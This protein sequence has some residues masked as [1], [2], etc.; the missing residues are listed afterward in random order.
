MRKEHI[1]LLCIALVV[2]IVAFVWWLGH[3]PSFEE[4]RASRDQFHAYAMTMPKTAA[5]LFSLIYIIAVAVSIPLATPLSLLAGFLFGSVWGTAIVVVSATIGATFTFVLARFFFREYFETK[6]AS[7]G[8]RATSH[9]FGTFGDVLIARLIPAVPFSLINV[10]AGLTQVSLRNYIM[11]TALGIVPFTFV[12]VHAGEALGE[13]NSL[14]DV[15]SSES[16]LFL[17]RIALVIAALYVVRRIY[18]SRAR[19]K[20]APP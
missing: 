6:I 20:D 8:S 9:S 13:L 5:L 16:A 18:A 14:G 1:G 4:V 10:V 17:S 19:T 2:S 3:I 15:A 12:Y 7:L 11:A